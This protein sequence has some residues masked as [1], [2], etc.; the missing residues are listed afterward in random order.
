MEDMH[1]QDAK[2]DMALGIKLRNPWGA[3]LA[4]SVRPTSGRDCSHARTMAGRNKLANNSIG[5]LS[6]TAIPARL[7][8]G[9]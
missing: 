9:L 1:T 6:P 4:H 3:A 8:V 7:K 2:R 5:E